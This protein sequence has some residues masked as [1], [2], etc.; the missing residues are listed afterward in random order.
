MKRLF[1]IA[2]LIILF[3]FQAV[4]I[5]SQTR[6]LDYYL[7]SGVKNSP[8]LN[9]LKNQLHSASLDS[10]IIKAQLKPQVEGRSQLLYSPFGNNIG[11]DEVITD[12]GNYQAVAYVSQ[13]LLQKKKTTN[14]YTALDIEKQ[15]VR[16]SSGVTITDLKKDIT[17]LYLQSYAEYSELSFN[18]SFLSLMKSE[19]QVIKRFADNGVCSQSDYLSLLVETGGVEVIIN[20][21]R[22]RYRSDIMA[23]NEICGI[24]D[25]ASVI[26]ELPLIETPGMPNDHNYIFLRQYSIDS[27]KIINEREALA[28][29]YKPSVN[30]FADAGILTSNPLNFY[31]HAGISAGVSLTVPIYDG[32]QKKL[33]GDKLSLK[34]STRV[35]YLEV[36]RRQYDQDYLKLCD[37]L[38]GLNRIRN[39]L[40]NQLKLSDELVNSLKVQIESGIIKMQD[41]ISAIKN[42]RNIKHNLIMSDIDILRVKN[43][44]NHLLAK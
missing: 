32:H 10:L 15:G 40:N 24:L 8:L 41:Y 43:E 3:S 14:R 17:D 28:L 16:Y 7:T 20:Q 36:N 38:D 37:E 26:L 29:R 18:V 30:W 27:L 12:G 22:S 13:N 33:E 25:T 5:H 23:L 44:I 39:S 42:Q 1:Y 2:H 9:D 6:D 31:R 4:S 19:S 35:N 21:F 34:E 11:Y